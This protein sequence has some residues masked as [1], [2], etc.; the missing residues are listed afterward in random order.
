VSYLAQ[1]GLQSLLLCSDDKIV[2]VLRRVLTELEIGV[3]HC[4]ELDVAIQKL[5]RQRFE[6]IIVDC[7]TQAIAASMLKG[8]HSAPANKRA[9]AVAIIDGQS[10]LKS[11]FE[12]GAHF[13]LFKPISL[14]RTKAS[15]RS[16]RALMKRERRRHLRIPV[17]LAVTVQSSD[18]P[19]T[20][21]LLTVDLSENGVGT[22]A[23]VQ[24]P[25]QFRVRFS[26][27]GDHNEIDCRGE[28]AWRAKNVQGIRFRDL[29]LEASARLKSW[30]FR[31]MNGGDA[32]DPPVLCKLSDLS[33]NACYLE[34]ESPFPVRTRLQITM[35]AGEQE[36]PV[37]GMVRI[38]HPAAGIGVQFTR[39][40][41]EAKSKVENFIHTLTKIKD[42][43]PQIEVRPDSIDNS[44]SAFSTM[45]ADDSDPLLTLFHTGSDLAPDDF[46]AALHNQRF[47]S[48]Q[49]GI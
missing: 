26:L 28:A 20:I 33:L 3:E 39:Q 34:T 23:N 4:T 6:A 37:E 24:L 40:T 41:L 44:P 15:F 14:E 18:P 25:A 42:A 48:E 43:V 21:E 5:T 13:V 2:R 49:V 30:I 27:P 38:M 8:V 16:V 11:A 46:R 32:D 31:Q 17:E 9:I 22:K 12:L 47:A 36:L 10:A 19:R 35:K 29:S 45:P 7:T 1:P